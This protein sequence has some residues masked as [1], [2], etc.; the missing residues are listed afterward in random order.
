MHIDNDKVGNNVVNYELEWQPYGMI[1]IITEVISCEVDPM[2]LTY[3]NYKDQTHQKTENE[4]T[5]PN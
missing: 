3:A 1:H 2:V 4:N 5:L